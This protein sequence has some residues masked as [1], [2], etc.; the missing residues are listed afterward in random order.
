MFRC[1]IGAF[2]KSVIISS[3]SEADRI[4]QKL[5]EIGIYLYRM[6]INKARMPNIPDQIQNEFK[7]QK[8]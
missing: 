8:K 2:P 4:K 5:E 3:F 7:K 6:V 1:F